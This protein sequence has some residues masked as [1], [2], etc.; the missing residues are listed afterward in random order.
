MN[1]FSEEYENPK[2]AVKRFETM[3]QLNEQYYFDRD[4][5]ENIVEFYIHENH[6]Q[7][8][9]RVI[10]FA[11]GQYPDS[12]YFLLRKSQLLSA[13]GKYDDALD[14]LNE[15]EIFEPGNPEVFIT[16]GG[17]YAM[18]G[19]SSDAIE[20]YKAAL[21]IDRNFDEIYLFIAFEFQNQGKYGKAAR[22][23]RRCLTMNPE[24][25][26][27]IYEMSFCFDVTNKLDA[28][29]VFFNAF[30]NKYP[31]SKVAWYA[32]GHLY[33]KKQDYINGI[34][35]FDYATV[36]DDGFASA[37]FNKANCL[38]AS[39]KYEDAIEA[40]KEIFRLEEPDAATFL[41]IGECYENIDQYP[42]ALKYY[43][44]SAS[45]DEM[46]ADAWVGIGVVLDFMDR[47]NEALVHIKKGINIEPN[48]GTFWFILGDIQLKMGFVQEAEEA[49]LKVIEFEPDNE[50][51]WFFMSNLMLQLNR[52]DDAYNFIQE[53]FKY[54]P[55]NVR[56]TFHA[57][58]IELH[59]GNHQEA[60]ILAEIALSMGGNM[61]DQSPDDIPRLFSLPEFQNL[62]E[63]Y[64]NKDD[65]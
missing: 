64:K 42:E 63:R 57:S 23:L 5:L 30:I 9:L 46:L 50:D 21:R 38:A 31:Y 18:L 22:Y 44:R 26:S 17:I 48:R 53:S 24:N 20:S 47:S 36:I 61:S 45:L 10:K 59:R 4:D 11:S 54:H 43:Q 56:L 27:A 35:A 29:I 37:W 41:Y 12:T 60:L 2:F 32:L 55:G 15:V 14:L 65:R 25:E 62:V 13:D 51:I 39:E 19:R 1:E 49:Y 33:S 8:A 40:Y 28:G 58:E 3:L 34:K 6:H 16:R 52:K 7:K